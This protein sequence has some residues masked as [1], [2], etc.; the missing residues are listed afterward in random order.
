M[1]SL[2]WKQQAQG[3]QESAQG[4]LYICYG[5]KLGAFVGLLTEEA[6]YL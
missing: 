4:P 2:R 6:V 5:C 3:L 1:G